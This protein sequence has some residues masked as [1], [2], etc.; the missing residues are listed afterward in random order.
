MSEPTKRRTTHPRRQARPAE[1]AA[2]ADLRAA[3]TTHDQIKLIGQR[4]GGSRRELGRLIE[5]QKFGA[6][7]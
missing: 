5:I 2:R 4:R 1:A 3:R 6:T 7:S